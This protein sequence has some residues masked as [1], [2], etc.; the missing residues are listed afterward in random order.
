LLPTSQLEDLAKLLLVKLYKLKTN[1]NNIIG[2]IT[3]VAEELK[4]QSI[5]KGVDKYTI[6]KIPI[7]KKEVNKTKLN[8]FTF[9]VINTELKNSSKEIKNF[10]LRNRYSKIMIWFLN[11]DIFFIKL[12]K[13]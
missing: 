7:Y 8:I 1:N 11:T 10:S 13:L 5:S 9:F 6:N 12:F 4:C 2:L 3:L